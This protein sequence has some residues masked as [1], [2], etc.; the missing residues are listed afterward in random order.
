MSKEATE[1]APVKDDAASRAALNHVVES[2]GQWC[3]VASLKQLYPGCNIEQ[4]K[5]GGLVIFTSDGLA[6]RADMSIPTG[7]LR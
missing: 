7:V 1:V 3:T 4:Y 2:R 6:V 5:E